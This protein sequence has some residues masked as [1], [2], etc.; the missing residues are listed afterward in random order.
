MA[1]WTTLLIGLLLRTRCAANLS[2]SLLLI[3]DTSCISSYEELNSPNSNV[4]KS[5]IVLWRRF[6]ETCCNNGRCSV[7]ADSNVPTTTRNYLSL[8]SDNYADLNSTCTTVDLNAGNT[9]C[10][11][12]NEVNQADQKMKTLEVYIPVC[13]SVTCS[14]DSVEHVQLVNPSPA[15]CW[16]VNNGYGDCKILST[17]VQWPVTRDPNPNAGTCWLDADQVASNYQ[18]LFLTQKLSRTMTRACI[19][20]LFQEKN[21]LC[22]VFTT[23]KTRL[24]YNYSDF[25]TTHGSDAGVESA[26]QTEGYTCYLCLNYDRTEHNSVYRVLPFP[27]SCCGCYDGRTMCLHLLGQ[28]TLFQLIQKFGSTQQ[29]FEQYLPEP[30]SDLQKLPMLIENIIRKDGKIRSDAQK[31][32]RRRESECKY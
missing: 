6:N 16:S 29:D 26:K 20:F 4:A 18:M 10:L 25:V 14:T 28:L 1:K 8:S 27:N 5:R 19:G 30:T 3:T 24:D 22:S 17:T 9:V 12:S 32:R 2:H 31:Q 23:I 15:N 21:D 7:K 11:V 13:F